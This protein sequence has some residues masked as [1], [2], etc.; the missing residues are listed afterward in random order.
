MFLLLFVV[1]RVLEQTIVKL[2][3][4]NN[5]KSHQTFDTIYWLIVFLLYLDEKGKAKLEEI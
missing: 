4:H 2:V 3:L 1:L 5:E